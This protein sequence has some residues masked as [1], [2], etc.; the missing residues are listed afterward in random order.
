MFK[1]DFRFGVWKIK[2]ELEGTLNRQDANQ[3]QKEQIAG[4]NNH[5]HC[6]MNVSRYSKTPHKTGNF[7]LI[8]YHFG[9]VHRSESNEMIRSCF[10]VC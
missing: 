6:N 8:S 10:L 5:W 2:V 9:C 1:T 4:V 7:L 3:P